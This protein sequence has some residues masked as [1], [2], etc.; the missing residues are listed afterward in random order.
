[1]IRLSARAM[2]RVSSMG[3]KITPS[4]DWIQ[5]RLESVGMRPIN[6]IVDIT[7]FVMLEY[8]QP[9]HAF[10]LRKIES[11][12]P[13]S[14]ALQSGSGIHPAQWTDGAAGAR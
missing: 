12:N 11:R 8:G 3:L 10:D 9:L 4:A 5:Q 2:S 14:R 1:M 6:N 7:N 13:Q